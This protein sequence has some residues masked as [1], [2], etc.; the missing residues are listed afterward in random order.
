M[1]AKIDTSGFPCYIRINLG[2]EEY[3]DFKGEIWHADKAY[4]SGS[5]GCPNLPQTDVLI[6]T[7]PISNTQDS[8]LF[9]SVRMGEKM[10]YHFDVP[11]GDYEVEILFAEIYWETGSAEQQDI[12]IQGK[13]VLRAFNI[14]DEAGH[15]VALMKRFRTKITEGSLEVKFVGR[16]LPMHSGARACAIEVRLV[17]G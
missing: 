4:T 16:S 11:N 10:M 17:S 7:D 13:R 12:Y 6:T 2:G 3:R 14:F 9:Q 1:T 5:W 8:K 15:D